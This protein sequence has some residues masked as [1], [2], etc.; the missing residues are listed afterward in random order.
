MQKLP[1]ERLQ[2]TL[3]SE[4]LANGLTVYVLPKPGFQ[5][6]YATFSAKFGSIDNHFQSGNKAA[7]RVPDGIAHFLEHKLFA[8]P[9]G[10]V[11]AT[12]SAQGAAANAFTSFDRTTYLF[13]A[14]GNIAKNLQTLLDFVQNPYFTDENVEKEKGIIGQ[15]INMYRDNPDWRN[16]YGLVKALYQQHPIR[17]DIAGS[18]DSIASIDKQLL[19]DCYH[20]FYHP[21]NMQLFIVGGVDAAEIIEL[22]KKNQERKTFAAAE[23]INRYFPQEPANVKT[24]EI[25][26]QLPVSLPKC[27]LGIKE[28]PLAGNG[29]D[30]LKRECEMK[31]LLDMLFGGSSRL[32]QELYEDNLISDQFGY[33]YQCAPG[34]AFSAVGGETRDPH[35]LVERI[36]ERV[37]QLKESGLKES[38]F[39][40]NRKKRIGHF[41]RLLNS[42]EAIAHEFTKY[43]FRGADLFAMLSIYENMRFADVTKRLKRHFD[44]DRLAV[45]IV[46]GDAT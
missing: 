34:Y 39:E 24:R 16:Y 20:T 3:Y 17:I 19:Y 28:E 26:V 42:P 13:S 21:A 15:E 32:Y 35:L 37:D 33:E 8:E 9:T 38:D 2:E 43:R 10:D 4:T 6:T 30:L 27:L 23:K 40:R 36:K 22:V 29:S 44:W 46:R 25:V 11:F 18:L 5:K 1:Y 45:S 31:V 7:S 12:F 14:T 41:L